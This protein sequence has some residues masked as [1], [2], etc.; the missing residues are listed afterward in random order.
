MDF[1]VKNVM[2]LLPTQRDR[3]GLKN[4]G[5]NYKLHWLSDENFDYPYPKDEFDM[6]EY[7]EMCS[8]YIKNNDI[9]AILYSHDFANLVAGVLCERHNLPGPSLESI[10][11]TT[12]KYYS[13]RNQPNTIWSDYIDLKT[14]EWG[15][16]SPTIP[17]YI[18]PAS[19]MMTL[20]QHTIESVEQLDKNLSNLKIELP[21]LLRVCQK[22]FEKNEYKRRIK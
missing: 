9:N 21:P 8:Q 2:V 19:L 12:H 22:F 17:C 20:H 15:E 7:T 14:G 5:E 4:V 18:K 3:E 1:K 10:F 13:R 11:L 16:L 6:V